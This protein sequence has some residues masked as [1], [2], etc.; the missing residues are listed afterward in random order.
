MCVEREYPLGVVLMGEYPLGV[1]I[2]DMFI[3]DR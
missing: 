1:F 3:G 2:G